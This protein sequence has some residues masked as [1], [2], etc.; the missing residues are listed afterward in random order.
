VPTAYPT[1]DELQTFLEDQG[2]TAPADAQLNLHRLR[3]IEDL[4]VR[5]G[6]RPFLADASES[7]WRFDPPA[8][9]S[10]LNLSGG[11]WAISE[12]RIGLTDIDT[13]GTLLT[14]ETD[15]ILLP[16][17]HIALNRPIEEIQFVVSPGSRARSIKIKG[18]RGFSA[19]IPSDVYQA[20]IERAAALAMLEIVQGHSIATEIKQGPIDITYSPNAANDKI[21]KWNSGFNDVV[22]RY[23]RNV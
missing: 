5:T 22:R 7:E 1:T 19:T 4:E 18:A 11:F 23:R 13:D 8:F 15:Y 2:L 10:P 12:V 21:G 3:A 6:Y 9:H 17:N 16:N 14:E 20:I